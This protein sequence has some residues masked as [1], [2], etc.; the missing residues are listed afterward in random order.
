[1]A[2]VDGWVAMGAA[3]VAGALFNE[4]VVGGSDGVPATGGLA[5]GTLAPG[6]IAVGVL[7]AGTLVACVCV[8]AEPSF[9]NTP[10]GRLFAVAIHPSIWL[11]A[12]LFT[13]YQQPTHDP[14]MLLLT[15]QTHP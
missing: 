14:A 12:F 15:Q 3:V 11:L 5:T 2:G 8:G 6:E 9:L 4:G 10:L 13:L 7:A 1:M